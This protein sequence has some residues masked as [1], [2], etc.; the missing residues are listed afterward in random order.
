VFW[1]SAIRHSSPRRTATSVCTAV[2]RVEIAAPGRNH[3][4]DR[5]HDGDVGRE[6]MHVPDLPDMRGGLVIGEDPFELRGDFPTAVHLAGV[7]ADAPVVV[8]SAEP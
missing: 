8:D 7:E 3:A 5:A 1:S 6:E 2:H 4:R